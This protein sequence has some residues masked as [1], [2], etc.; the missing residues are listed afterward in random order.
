MKYFWIALR[1]K[2]FVLLASFRV[3]LPLWRALTHDLSKF[4]R[5]ELLPYD[6]W[7]FGAKDNPKEFARAWLHH[8]NHNPHHPEYWIIRSDLTDG[9]SGVVDGCLEMPE[10]HIR[11][12]I[13][14]WMGASKAHTGSWDMAKWLLEK[15]S[16]IQLHP[17]TRVRVNEL[18]AEIGYG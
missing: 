16:R 4:T 12:M 3:R 9:K 18:L 15:L 17:Y 14:D 13:A 2:W 5:A 8:Q 10:V 6:R 11:E 1:H 7:F